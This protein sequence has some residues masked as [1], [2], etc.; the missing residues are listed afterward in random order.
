MLFKNRES[1][2]EKLIPF[3]KKYQDKDC[4]VLAIPRGGIPVAY[5][6]AKNITFQ[7]MLCSLKKSGIL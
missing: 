1:A 5:S 4:I 3:L 6:I 2:S 7:W